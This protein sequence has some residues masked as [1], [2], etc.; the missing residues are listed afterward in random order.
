MKLMQENPFIVNMICSAISYL[1]TNG[2]WNIIRKNIWL[3]IEIQD[4]TS[5]IKVKQ[6]PKD[7]SKVNF[8]REGV[9]VKHV[10]RF[11]DSYIFKRRSFFVFS[12]RLQV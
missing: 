4:L 3:Q 12:D 5:K 1:I 11:T 10:Y 8:Q 7:P 2:L 9:I 6:N